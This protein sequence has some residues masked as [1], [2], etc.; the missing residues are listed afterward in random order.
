MALAV[1]VVWFL[2]LGAV[3]TMAVLRTPN[4]RAQVALL[5]RTSLPTL[6]ILPG[7]L[8]GSHVA[9][10]SDTIRRQWLDLSS[11]ERNTLR[12]PTAQVLNDVAAARQDVVV[13][14]FFPSDQPRWR[15]VTRRLRRYEERSSFVHVRFVDPDQQPAHA[16]QY[17]IVNLGDVFVEVKP[18]AT[19]TVRRVRADS[20]SEAD[21]TTAIVRV[22]N[23]SRLLCWSSGHGERPSTDPTLL[24]AAGRL[25]MNG[26]S[27]REG[28][29]AQGSP[30]LD[31]CS[32]L[33]IASPRAAPLP[34]ETNVLDQYLSGGGRVL[35]LLDPDDAAD[36]IAQQWSGTAAI[37]V[38][39][40]RVEDPLGSVEREPGALSA[41]RFPSASPIT[42]KLPAVLFLG[43]RGLVLPPDQPERGRT[44]AELVTASEQTRTG[45]RTAPALAASLDVSYVVGEGSAS[46]VVR[47]RVVA[48][49]DADWLQNESISL[50]GNEDMWIRTVNWLV[51]APTL[52][53]ISS[54]APDELL[55]LTRADRRAVDVGVFLVPA[56]LVGT[57]SV[58][59][60]LLLTARRRRPRV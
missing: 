9:Q 5:A 38:L 42:E 22:V 50:V 53:S 41:S 1:A 27:I 43:A 16:R 59:R 60:L 11:D 8:L 14:G 57:A 32:A 36:A 34:A 31:G 23:G 56:L 58:V 7:V 20:A 6:V 47:T 28:R 12:P 24:H 33:V 39:P 49:G 44:G 37:D 21:V 30:F 45:G 52:V 15:P 13:T 51:E 46:H 40:G 2:L 48:F 18:P 54:A 25:Q 35:L 19:G 10:R 4:R 29:L 26:F 55:I 17:E 3:A